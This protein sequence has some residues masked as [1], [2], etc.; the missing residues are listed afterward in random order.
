MVEFSTEFFKLF[1]RDGAAPSGSTLDYAYFG[2]EF[3]MFVR[4]HGNAPGDAIKHPTEDFFAGAPH[5]FTFEDFLD[6]DR[7]LALELCDVSRW[8]NV[9]YSS[10]DGPCCSTEDL[11]V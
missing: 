1:L 8:K 9:K 5:A 3:C 2:L 10:E 4:W 6:G 11:W 7:V